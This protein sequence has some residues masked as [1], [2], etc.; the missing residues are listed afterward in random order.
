VRLLRE[1]LAEGDVDLDLVVVGNG[2]EA[3]A[4]LR[5]A[6]GRTD[7]VLMDVNLPGRSG[8]EVLEELR[9][10]TALMRIPV[11]ILAGSGAAEDVAACY[12]AGANAY[13][14][15]PHDLD[16]FTAAVQAI[17]RFWLRVARLPSVR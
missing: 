11:V 6:P 4:A 14:V 13:V 10:D 9:R 1:A 12:D 17:T 16:D 5:V 2:D 3:L 7:L 8:R 15:K